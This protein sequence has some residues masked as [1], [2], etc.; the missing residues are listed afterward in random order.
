MALGPC[1]LLGNVVTERIIPVV[2]HAEICDDEPVMEVES[3]VMDESD[4][5]R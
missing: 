5:V 1:N 3:G 2:G 4:E